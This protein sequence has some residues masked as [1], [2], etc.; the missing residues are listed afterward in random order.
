MSYKVRIKVGKGKNESAQGSILLPNKSRVI[1]YIKR[2]PLVKSNTNI[3]VVNTR[4]KKRKTGKPY[5]FY[6]KKF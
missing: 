6:N 3:T 1:S 5:E 4:T 2:S